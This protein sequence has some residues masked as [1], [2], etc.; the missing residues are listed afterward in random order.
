LDKSLLKAKKHETRN[1]PSQIVSKSITLLRDVDTNIF[2]KLTDAEKENLRGQLGRL[3][4]VVER[5]DTMIEDGTSTDKAAP[6]ETQKTVV[7]KV[8]SN[9]VE[10]PR[11]YIAR[12]HADEPFI[13]CLTEGKTITN[14]GMSV[15]FEPVYV[16]QSQKTNVEYRAFFIDEAN[17]IISDVKPIVLCSGERCKVTF[18]LN[19]KASSCPICML[20][21]QSSADKPDE[22]QQLIPFAVNISFT[23]DFDF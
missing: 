14:L 4:T 3:S 12:R 15:E 20:A 7:T 16:G 6:P 21:L 17:E 10:K 2:E 1:R 23:S 22:L 19:P 13:H 11:F 9:T 18:A 5:F 8:V